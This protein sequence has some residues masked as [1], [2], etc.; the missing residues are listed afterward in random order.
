MLVLFAAA[1]LVAVV[2][3]AFLVFLA[4]GELE[5][6]RDG[7]EADFFLAAV[8]F[9]GA[10]LRLAAVFFLPERSQTNVPFN[11]SAAAAADN[12]SGEPMSLRL[13]TAALHAFWHGER[14]R[15]RERVLLAFFDP[16]REREPERERP[17]RAFFVP[18][19]EAERERDLLAARLAPTRFA[20]ETGAASRGQTRVPFSACAAAAADRL[21][22]PARLFFEILADHAF[23]HGERERPVR[24]LR[25]SGER[26]LR[27]ERRFGILVFVT[28]LQGYNLKSAYKKY[29]NLF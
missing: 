16:E 8:F 10:A 27:L 28:V 4:V 21:G 1:A 11:S 12:G 29:H 14:D 25:R 3:L 6:E 15:E 7:D 19:R 17:V 24:G 23:W 20:A 13:A 9:F 18:E 26:L 22:L 2:L 5:R